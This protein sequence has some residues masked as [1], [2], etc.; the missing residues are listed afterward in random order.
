MKQFILMIGLIIFA[1]GLA[2]CAQ[3]VREIET[4]DEVTLQA[5]QERYNELQDYFESNYNFAASSEAAGDYI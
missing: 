4:V 1:S 2:G 5:D 3:Q